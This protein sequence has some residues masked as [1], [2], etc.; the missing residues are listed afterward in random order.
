MFDQIEICRRDASLFCQISLPE[1]NH[2]APVADP[3]ACQ[4]AHRHVISPL[5]LH[6]FQTE[7]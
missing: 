3:A 4:T 2:H 7:L 6:C 5:K 1:T